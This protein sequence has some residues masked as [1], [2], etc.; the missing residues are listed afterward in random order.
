MHSLKYPLL[1]EW[2]TVNRW[3]LSLLP[4]HVN[5][6]AADNAMRQLWSFLRMGPR[7]YIK[8]V[9]R[10]IVKFRNYALIAHW[11]ASNTRL[12]SYIV[13][14]APWKGH[15]TFLDGKKQRL[16]A[17]ERSIHGCFWYYRVF[18]LTWHI[19]PAH[20]SHASTNKMKPFPSSTNHTQRKR[21]SVACLCNG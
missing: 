12:F 13:R 21:V 19:S 18:T 4:C 7:N 16:E 10:P 20:T 3:K 8:S 17:V 9:T 1:V 6:Q 2:N 15:A 14:N 11:G 5:H